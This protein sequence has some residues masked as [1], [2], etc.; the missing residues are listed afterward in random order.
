MPVCG[1]DSME[2]TITVSLGARSVS[3]EINQTL[4]KQREGYIQCWLAEAFP[5][6]GVVKTKTH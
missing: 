6:H 3:I 2:H 5:Y 1:T 4:K